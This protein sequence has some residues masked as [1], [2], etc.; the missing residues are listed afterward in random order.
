MGLVT[1]RKTLPATE[2]LEQKIARQAKLSAE[3]ELGKRQV[4]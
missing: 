2:N 1:D 3:Y 4:L